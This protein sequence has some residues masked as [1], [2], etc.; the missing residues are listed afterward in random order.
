MSKTPEEMAVEYADES[1]WHLIQDSWTIVRDAYLAGY[2]AAKDQLADA[3]KV[4]CNT[5]MEE[6]KAVDT[7]ELM[8][9]T[10]LPTS[11]KWISVKDRLPEL[12]QSSFAIRKESNCVLIAS[13]G[14]VHVT[15]L[16]EKWYD[17][18]QVVFEACDCGC[19]GH[20][21]EQDEW[22]LDKVTHWMPLPEPPKEEK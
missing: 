7:G 13:D 14:N 19:R 1:P 15:H 18:T 4:M 16:C 2:K 11:A 21:M 6:I 12:E 3:D 22:E 17:R 10:N 20:D 5:K 8:P 9:M